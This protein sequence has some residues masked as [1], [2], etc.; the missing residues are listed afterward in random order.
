MNGRYHISICGCFV[1]TIW[2][3]VCL[4]IYCIWHQIRT[5]NILYQSD[6][7]RWRNIKRLNES[8]HF[9]FC[10]RTI[11]SICANSF[12][13]CPSNTT[14]ANEKP[15]EMSINLEIIRIINKTN[16]NWLSSWMR[17]HQINLQLYLLFHYFCYVLLHFQLA[18]SVFFIPYLMMN[19]LSQ[20]YFN[21]ILNALVALSIHKIYSKS[22]KYSKFIWFK[23][24]I[25]KVSPATTNSYNNDIH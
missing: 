5:S 13:I 4:Y 25:L 6:C 21:L 24:M 15:F 20:M 3:K 12:E 9:H 2:L 16:W 17:M 22:F 11:F 19:D 7:S 23:M 18:R 1:W 10:E 8:W 14:W